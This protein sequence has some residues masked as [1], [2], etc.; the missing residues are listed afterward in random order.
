M[1]GL[2]IH[3]PFCLKKCN[4]CDFASFPS[5][6]SRG[7]EYIDAICR[8]MMLYKGECV[9]TV[10]LGGGT[11]TVLKTD[12]IGRI[13]DGI[14][15]AFDVSSDAEITIEANPGT[16]DG[17]KAKSLCNLGFN[18]VS[19]GAQSMVDDELQSLGRLHSADDTRRAY[20]AFADAGFSNI[21][22]DLMYAIP[23]QTMAS[24]STS[25]TQMLNLNP[26]HISCYGLKIEDGTP[27]DAMLSKGEICEK[28]DE[29]YADMYD[30]I[31]ESL[32][33]H[34]YMQYEL[35]NFSKSSY[36]SRHN[37]KYWTSG[38]YIGIG[39]SAASCF[40]GRR[41]TR[42]SDFADYIES[43]ENAECI[44]LDAD[45]RMSE[46]MILSLRLTSRG[47]IK[48][49]FESMFGISMERRFGEAL[50]KHVKNGL[51]LDLGDRYVL[52]KKAYYI[53]NSVLCD[54]I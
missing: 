34:D 28:S 53:S 4:Y 40:G 1:N 20:A 23:G 35:S 46:Y 15:T 45:D 25:M 36:E 9:D 50:A 14:R 29:E 3:I 27:F 10:Y 54:F 19:L 51:L 41:Y 2:Y 8:E 33:S 13:M 5:L 44:E 31:C 47:A 22:L 17:N 43:F 37:L 42:T 26:K 18:R 49:E 6:V 16:V 38:D 24:L 30:Y 48:S 11:P 39:L 32:A 7:D 12:Q 21:S 52:S